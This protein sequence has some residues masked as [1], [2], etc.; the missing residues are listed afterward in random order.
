MD[1]TLLT[2]PACPYAEVFERRLAAA[3]ARSLHAVVRRR[4][5]ASEQEAAG[6]GPGAPPD[7]LQGAAPQ[8][9]PRV[10]SLAGCFVSGVFRREGDHGARQAAA[11]LRVMRSR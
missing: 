4:E 1:L 5:I 6:A 8:L 2:A 10:H 3:P 7:R 9:P 11:A